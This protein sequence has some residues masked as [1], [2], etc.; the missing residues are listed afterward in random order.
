[1][2]KQQLSDMCKSNKKTG[3]KIIYKIIVDK[4]VTEWYTFDSDCYRIVI[5]F[6]T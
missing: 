4:T 6:V 1:M 5:N 3:G 2:H